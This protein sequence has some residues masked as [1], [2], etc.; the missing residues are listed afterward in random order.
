M[1]VQTGR[2]LAMMAV[3]MGMTIVVATATGCA[4][5]VELSE[6]VPDYMEGDLETA[7]VPTPKQ[8]DLKDVCV[9]LDK[10][11]VCVCPEVLVQAAQVLAEK[12]LLEKERKVRAANYENKRE[13]RKAHRGLQ[14]QWKAARA[15]VQAEDWPS[16]LDT[17][18]ELQDLFPGITFSAE[19]PADQN[20]PLLLFLVTDTNDGV[21]KAA[22]ISVPPLP[23]VEDRWQAAERYVVASDTVKGRPVVACL[24][25]NAWGALWGVET[26]RQMVF[27][28]D[29]KQYLRLGTVVDW[30]TLWFRGGKR[31]QDWWVRCKGNGRFE[32]WSFVW[33]MR[34]L[35]RCHSHVVSAKE[36]K[37]AKYRATLKKAVDAGADLFL[38]DFNDGRFWTPDKEDE[39]F[40]GDPARTVKHILS[41]IRKERKKLDSDIWIGYMPVGY[42]INRGADE[43]ADALKAVEALKGTEFLMMNGLEV[44]C[45][46]FPAAGAKAYIDAFG[47]DGKL[48]MY[49]CQ[50]LRRNLRTPDYHDRDVAQHLYGISA[51]SSSPIFFI[52][53]TDF[54]WNPEA[55]DPDRALRLAARELADRDPALYKPLIDYLTYFIEKSY[56][57]ELHPRE[58]TLALYKEATDG[59][60]AR[61]EQLAPLFERSKVAALTSLE[62]YIVPPVKSREKAW[63]MLEQHGF[64]TYAVGRAEGVT[65]DGKLDEAA[66]QKAP[67]MESFFAPPNVK[68]LSRKPLPSEGRAIVARALYDGEALYTAYEVKGTSEKMME[69]VRGSVEGDLV[70]KNA[71]KK[72][73]FEMFIK[74]DLSE[75]VRW[76]LMHFVP[77]GHKTYVKHY[78]DPKE[79]F[80]ANHVTHD[81]TFACT[82]TGKTSYTVEIRI[83]FWKGVAKPK[84]GTVWGVQLQLN[85]ALAHRGTPFW[86]YHWS[87]SPD[88]TGLW[89]YEYEYGR[90]VF[91][92]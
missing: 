72:P 92:D 63:P 28:K 45:N 33:D 2:E 42:A 55:Y 75:V 49:D 8:A 51:Q 79:P 11:P 62:S 38:I 14:N 59:M 77:E 89:A 82:V 36:G 13:R 83:P 50:G 54:T 32:N 80:A 7:I 39:P 30:P 64:K 35:P 65:I 20:R 15:R 76:Q 53:L 3:V 91:E 37:L 6:V 84:P 56:I 57:D 70:E 86:L 24:G 43:E 58:K 71:K 12:E 19:L 16:P 23:A 4:G 27:R 31:C 46:Q 68:D 67:K 73:V 21:A 1:Q 18:A 78:F 85:R 69:Y 26:L 87:Y 52:G 41:E 9:P 61:L 88:S 17:A 66:W 10:P 40:P 90:W 29:G 44:F 60:L 34:H 48:M 5:E 74:P 47:A 25:A 81:P 22:G